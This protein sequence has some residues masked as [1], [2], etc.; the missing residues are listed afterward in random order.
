MKATR[1]A[2]LLGVSLALAW[3][4]WVSGVQGYTSNVGSG[5]GRNW[6]QL[7]GTIL[8]ADCSLEELRATPPAPVSRLYQLNHRLG[9][10][11]IE[12]QHP[13]ARLQHHRLWLKGGNQLYETL[14]AE[15]NL[16]KEVEV[17]GLLREYLPTAG[18]LDLATVRIVETE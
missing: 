1:T 2:V 8:C 14:A 7:R 17:S 12:A 10:V 5:F 13:D 11:V 4:G 16:F 3:A 6:V 15:K 9:R 18:T